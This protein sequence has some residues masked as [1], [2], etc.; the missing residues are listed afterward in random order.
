M[1]VQFTS[2]VH[3]DGKTNLKHTQEICATKF[4]QL[5]WQSSVDTAFERGSSKKSYLSCAKQG[6]EWRNFQLSNASHSQSFLR[7]FKGFP[8]LSNPEQTT[9]TPLFGGVFLDKNTHKCNINTRNTY[10]DHLCKLPELIY[11]QAQIQVFESTTQNF[12]K[13]LEQ[14]LNKPPWLDIVWN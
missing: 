14:T 7:I 13:V 6:W 3:G 2:C 9:I 4:I 5:I 12:T 1:Y 10:E 8:V 11:N